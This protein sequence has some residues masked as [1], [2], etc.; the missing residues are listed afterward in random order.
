MSPENTASG[1]ALSERLAQYIHEAS[2]QDLSTEVVRQV[3]HVL[4]YH[5]GLALSGVRTVD[6]ESQQALHV[7][8]ELS[9]GRGTS[10]LIGRTQRLSLLDA[11]MANCTAMC[12]G[13]RDDVIFPTG[14]HPGVVTLPVALAIAARHHATGAAFI[15]AIVVAYEILGKF[16]RWTWALE[17][18]RR[19]SLLFGPF[20][21]VVVA[22]KLLNLQTDQLV[23]SLGYA[24]HMAIG[25]IGS[26]EGPLPHLYSLMCRNG[27]TGAY[28]AKVG[29]CASNITIEGKR[30][31][32]DAFGLP[33]LDSDALVSSLGRNFVILDSTEKPYPG[34]AL[35]NV[36]IGLMRELVRGHSLRAEDM[37]RL[38]IQLPI[39]RK[40]KAAAHSTGPFASRS[41]AV[42][43]CAFHLAIVLM[44][45]G[46]NPN[47]YDEFSN[48][49]IQALM[50]RMRVEFVTGKP[51]RYARLE[52]R[53][54]GGQMWVLEGEQ[55]PIPL[56]PAR[57]IIE[58]EAAGILPRNKIDRLLQLLDD[59]ENVTDVAEVMESLT[60]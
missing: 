42:C 20:G 58:R 53:T 38:L 28:L 33:G 37:E 41:E 24:V 36:P 21:S 52:F 60:P 15:N 11:V 39:E 35:N 48:P 12:S 1:T 32:W 47:R 4:A 29:A 2:I 23:S 34:T 44:H 51:I 57:E 14:I 40:N 43:S 54:T 59:L 30:G 56:E 27:L 50:G 3:K 22:G 13:G 25:V 26:D 16:G 10:R 49:D 46:P 19:A 31:F 17:T 55:S 18:P 45:G 5:L 7:A 9:E 8:S 6:R